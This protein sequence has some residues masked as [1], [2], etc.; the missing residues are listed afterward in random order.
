MTSHTTRPGPGGTVIVLTTRVGQF[1]ASAACSLVD[2]GLTPVIALMGRGGGKRRLSGLREYGFFYA[3]E[4]LAS[5]LSRRLW[6]WRHG[7]ELR[8]I[9]LM[10]FGSRDWDAL[11]AT[12]EALGCDMVVTA[13]FSHKIPPN[14]IAARQRFLNL[15]PAPLPEWKGADPVFWMLRT[16]Q[17]QLGLTLHVVSERID[18]GDICFR[19]L[20]DFDGPWL[21]PFAESRVA[22]VVRRELGGWVVEAMAGGS[23]G[24]PQEAPGSYW[25]M[26]T[27]ANRRRLSGL[28]SKVRRQAA[29]GR[30][31][32][33]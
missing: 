28:V 29:R 32:Q 2:A 26:P 30:P 10:Q 31:G 8:G 9:R 3:L 16:R 12:A 25:P 19:R 23:V 27:L 1:S 17:R 6:L 22:Q 14:V 11:L 33:P 5:A 24:S 18:E 7:R 4:Q 13:S 21:R 15:H 20:I